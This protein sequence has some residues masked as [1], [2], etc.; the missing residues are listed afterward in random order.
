M[1]TR[2][3]PAPGDGKMGNMVKAD[4]VM[5]TTIVTARGL[6]RCFCDVLG[7]RS[8]KSSTGAKP[9]KA[10]RGRD[11]TAFAGRSRRGEKK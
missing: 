5:T 1:G 7:L 10:N 8:L 11:V 2:Y 3:H 9:Q 4:E 6:Q